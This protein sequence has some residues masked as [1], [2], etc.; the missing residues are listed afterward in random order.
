MATKHLTYSE[1][2]E[3]WGVSRDAARKKVEGLR[4]PRKL[5]ND[6]K[7][8]VA[9]DLEEVTHV[10]K[11]SKEE[12]RRRP[13]GGQEEVRPETTRPPGLEVIA[14]QVQIATLEGRA[15]ELRKDL[16]RE[17]AETERERAE[18]IQ[19]RER[20]ERLTGELAEMA[21]RL[22]RVAEEAGVRERDLRDRVSKAESDL[23]AY[24]TAPWWKRLRRSA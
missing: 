7:T 14:L 3:L 22:A 1:L 23:V 11:P 21:C 12:T 13:D 17:R 5:G 18:R 20:A 6:G 24:K 19:E 10:P 9:I 8:R 2:S 15:V 4:L 16:E